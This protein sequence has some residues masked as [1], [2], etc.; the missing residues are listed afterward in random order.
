M[1]NRHGTN[2]KNRHGTNRIAGTDSPQCRRLGVK[3]SPLVSRSHDQGAFPARTLGDRLTMYEAH[4]GLRQRP[5]RPTPDSEGYY[6]ATTH[7]QAL[8]R[9]LRGIADD[10]GMLLLTGAPGTG[11]TL[12][13]HRLL[14]RLDPGTA[15]ALLTNGRVGSR[16]GLL[17]AILYEFSLPYEGR[18]G[19]EMRLA[20]TEFLLQNYQTGNRVVLLIDEAHHLSADLLEELRLLG[21]LEAGAGKAVQVVF[22]SQPAIVDTLGRPELAAVRQRLAVRVHLE[23]LDLHEA[24]DFLVHHLRVAGGRPEAIV[25]DEA[26]EVLAKG[27]RGIPRLLNQAA[28]Q[29]LLLA[30]QAEAEQVDVEAALEALDVLGLDAEPAVEEAVPAAEGRLLSEEAASPTEESATPAR[31]L[32]APDRRSA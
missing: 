3:F 16:A 23:P 30:C 11:K 27:T 21:N 29:A 4:F 12:L 2:M 24:V 9:L 7:E 13:C 32:F 28:H 26:L 10:E 19:Q 14:E 18:G 22:V 15:A 17:Q 5:F 6:A 8:G 31:C 25:A 1:N 20:L